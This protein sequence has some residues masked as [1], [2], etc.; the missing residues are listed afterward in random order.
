MPYQKQNL[1]EEEAAEVLGLSRRTLQMWR[2]EGKGP[3]YLKL[4][5]AIRY[6]RRDLEE[7]QRDAR[8]Q[9]TAESSAPKAAAAEA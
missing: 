8:R 2:Y 9:S 3:V 1:T 6:N 5:G 7:Y 4:G